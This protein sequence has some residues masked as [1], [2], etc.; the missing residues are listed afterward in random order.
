ML[1]K[2]EYLGEG[3][4]GNTPGTFRHSVR[5]MGLEAFSDSKRAPWG[6]PCD[7]VALHIHGSK[8]DWLNRGTVRSH[9]VLAPDHQNKRICVVNNLMILC[10][11]LP[12][13]FV[14]NT[15][16]PFARLTND[17]LISDRAITLVIKRAAAANGL[18]PDLYSLH[19]LRAGGATALFRATG[20]LDLVGR[21]GRCKGRSIH[22]YLWESHVVLTGIASLMTKKMNP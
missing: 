19:S 21:F 1:R 18:N 15:N 8:T 16:L 13:R 3:M 9:G 14:K 6:N 17:V 2:S 5:V 20:D 4:K 22:S 12:G 11:L 10:Q 7:S